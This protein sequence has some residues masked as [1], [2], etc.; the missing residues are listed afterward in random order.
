MKIFSRKR[1]SISKV[2]QKLIQRFAT[3]PTHKVT[4]APM[5]FLKKYF[6]M[7]LVTRHTF[8]FSLLKSYV[9]NYYTL[10]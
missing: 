9:V 7:T 5:Q 2:K 1:I 4:S 8:L 6:L 3:E 10:Q